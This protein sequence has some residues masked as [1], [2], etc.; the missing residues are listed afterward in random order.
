[1]RANAI[2]DKLEFVLEVVEQWVSNGGLGRMDEDSDINEGVRLDD[3]VK[4]LRWTGA[5]AKE[6]AKEKKPERAT[7]GRT[8]GDL[9]VTW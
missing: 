3:R 1:V 4:K 2:K 9:P 7:V 6:T 5:A 8:W